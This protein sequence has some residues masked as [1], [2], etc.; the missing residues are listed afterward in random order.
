M[1]DSDSDA[2]KASDEAGP[3]E[4]PNRRQKRT[5]ASKP[6]VYSGSSESDEEVPVAK[7]SKPRAKKSRK[8]S[9][10]PFPAGLF[11]G[12]EKERVSGMN[13]LER[14]MVVYK[15]M[16]ENELK[17]QREELRQKMLQKKQSDKKKGARKGGKL[18][19]D[20]DSA[21][22]ENEFESSSESEGE[23]REPK[24]PASKS[25]A[26]AAGADE[27]EA[28]AD[29]D[30][31][32]P[33]EVN[34][35]RSKKKAMDALLSKRR[36]KK[37]A[38]EKRKEQSG[39]S[40][41]RAVVDFDAIFGGGGGRDSASS[42][43]SSPS[44]VRS[45]SA[46]PELASKKEIDSIADLEKIKLSRQTLAKH[47]HLPDFEN[48]AKGSFVRIGIGN[49]Q[50][51]A[52]Y[53]IAE[54]SDVVETAKVYPIEGTRTNK[55]VKL[56]VGKDVR[57]YRLEFVSNSKF[58]D[59]EYKQWLKDMR[60]ADAKLPT[61]EDVERK[62]KEIKELLNRQFT[63]SDIDFMIK[64]K[65]RFQN[66]PINFAVEKSRLMKEKAGAEVEGNLARVREIQKEIDELDLRADEAERTRNGK[67]LAVTCINRK[68]RVEMTQNFLD[69][70]KVAWDPVRQDDPFTRKSNRMK[71]VSGSS[72]AKKDEEAG[73]SEADTTQQ[74][75]VS[76][77]LS[78]TAGSSSAFNSTVG[79]PSFVRTQT[80]ITKTT[81]VTTNGANG[82]PN[83]LSQWQHN[84][85]TSSTTTTTAGGGGGVLPKDL[86][87]DID[88]IEI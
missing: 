53:R 66:N 47:V 6:V 74:S 33:S 4:K 59:S 58:T 65:Q 61:M 2:G 5:A 26:G 28:E 12:V 17:K 70:T 80:E 71:V 51:K 87:I 11:E 67:L 60:T 57:V 27:D 49:H 88:D 55:G 83:F 8:R 41:N 45:R 73:K 19:S 22:E 63:D 32:R 42:G 7:A 24:V 39:A 23:I 20:E 34:E 14:E 48:L 78:E 50:G 3:S 69:A 40:D 29:M 36:D 18:D 15:K 75:T 46:S 37:Q 44:S 9:E 77:L 62:Q 1:S 56:K 13:E 16:E 68:R 30:Y 54:I 35:K 25:K 85:S 86:D 10:S 72:K 43:S 82:R 64:E 52:V 21:K 76:S 31:H 84:L 81:V 79:T 38:E